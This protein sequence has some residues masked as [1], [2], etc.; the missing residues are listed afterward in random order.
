MELIEE[1]ID[2]RAR[3]YWQHDAENMFYAY[4]DEE[5]QRFNDYKLRNGVGRVSD[6]HAVFDGID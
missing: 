3:Q 1:W 6:K 5:M 2:I 4:D